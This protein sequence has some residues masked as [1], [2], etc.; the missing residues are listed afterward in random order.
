M[1]WRAPVHDV[2]NVNDVAR[3]G[4]LCVDDVATAVPLGGMLVAALAA[5]ARRRDAQVVL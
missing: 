2:V 4:T 3:T 1:T 5:E